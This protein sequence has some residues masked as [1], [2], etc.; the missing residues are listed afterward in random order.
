MDLWKLARKDAKV[1]KFYI[2]VFF[3]T[4]GSMAENNFFYFDHAFFV[5]DTTPVPSC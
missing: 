4:P 3:Q 2:L 5:L 1:F